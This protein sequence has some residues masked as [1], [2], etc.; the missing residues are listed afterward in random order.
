VTIHLDR[1]LA[2]KPAR[3]SNLQSVFF[4]WSKSKPAELEVR[5]VGCLSRPRIGW[6]AGLEQL[7]HEAERLI[8][9]PLG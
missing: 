7:R 9:P 5:V 3:S 1:A 8:A 2:A 6:P 4:S